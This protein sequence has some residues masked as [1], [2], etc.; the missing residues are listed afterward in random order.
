[1]SMPI[2]G[3]IKKQL[4]QLVKP[5]EELIATYDEASKSTKLSKPDSQT[6][7][8]E[9]LLRRPA[10][11]LE[12]TPQP[13]VTNF[14][15]PLAASDAVRAL[16]SLHATAYTNGMETIYSLENVDITTV[17]RIGESRP[18][19]SSPMSRDP[20]PI[21]TVQSKELFDPDLDL[22]ESFRG[23]FEPFIL[24]EPIQVL[25]LSTQAEK[26]LIEANKCVIKD[27]LG[28]TARDLVFFKGMGQGHIDEVQQ[29]LQEYVKGRDL[30]KSRTID[31]GSLLRVLF[32]GDE[33][34]KVFL[35]CEAY[36]LSHL[37]PLTAVD[38]VALKRMTEPKRIE[39]RA[40][41]IKYLRQNKH[42]LMVDRCLGEICTVFVKPWMRRRLGLATQSE[43]IEYLENVSSDASV[44]RQTL[45]LIGDLF[46][47]EQWILSAY[48]I[49]LES[50]LFAADPHHEAGYKKIIAASES[51]FY[52]NDL[53][54][55]LDELVDCLE[56]E[57]SNQ[58]LSYSKQFIVNVLN[59]CSIFVIYK[60]IN[61]QLFVSI[62]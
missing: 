35:A 19:I 29:R 46:G 32:A 56:R 12:N 27:V 14:R 45:A 39:A 13:T 21:A 16:E 43:I 54:Y 55:Q 49:E 37:F 58:W 51:Y 62:S 24:S 5:V 31:F 23:W 26:S 50:Q 8:S 36:K 10:P 40:E 15:A 33:R 44:C 59:Y 42:K 7:L 41:A 48:L 18:A 25:G 3:Q 34:L 38:A 57:F 17:R 61:N 9:S 30:E 2:F 60:Q 52:R 6:I 11:T 20:T 22:G 53:Q 47:R 4:G 28:I 1:M